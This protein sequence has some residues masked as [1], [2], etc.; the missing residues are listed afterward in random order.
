MSI[1]NTSESGNYE[2]SEKAQELFKID[3]IPKY[4]EKG[5]LGT[6]DFHTY[7]PK[8][9]NYPTIP[10]HYRV[11][12][13]NQVTGSSSFG[14]T[15]DYNLTAHINELIVGILHSFEVTA[16][17][18]KGNG[19]TITATDLK[20]MVKK[21]LKNQLTKSV[22]NLRINKGLTDAQA[23][24]VAAAVINDADANITYTIDG[25]TYS[26]TEVLTAWKDGKCRNKFAYCK[27]AGQKL[28][29]Q[30]T[31]SID[32]VSG[33]PLSGQSLSIL[34]ENLMTEDMNN[35]LD[36]LNTG[37]KPV[38]ISDLNRKGVGLTETVL[39]NSNILKD[40][41]A[42]VFAYKQ[43]KQRFSVVLPEMT[44]Y[45]EHAIFKRGGPTS[46]TLSVSIKR[47]EF[48]SM[49]KSVGTLMVHVNE[50]SNAKKFIEHG[51]PKAFS[52]AVPDNDTVYTG[53]N[54][55]SSSIYLVTQTFPMT[56]NA[57]ARE[58]SS[59]N[60]TRF[61]EISYPAA[62]AVS[63]QLSGLRGMIKNIYVYVKDTSVDKI[64]NPMRGEDWALGEPVIRHVTFG[65][66]E[67]EIALGNTLHSP[68]GTISVGRVVEIK[69]KFSLS[70]GSKLPINTDS[71]LESRII[72]IFNE[73]PNTTKRGWV[74]PLG[75]SNGGDPSL[76]GSGII[77]KAKSIATLRINSEEMGRYCDK[78]KASGT[79]DTVSYIVVCEMVNKCKTDAAGRISEEL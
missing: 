58:Y 35:F 13:L 71:E 3:K 61:V 6:L 41:S 30:M 78:V 49:I 67:P 64:E 63:V 66:A 19:R 8:S 54:L 11:Y 46:S 17:A 23:E 4:E 32:S 5:F 52:F 27:N 24:S 10:R 77:P 65:G 29:N 16:T 60:C 31:F 14:S 42:S 79:G 40:D 69:P 70:M 33:R 18:S 76:P 48:T 47:E 44:G 74:L 75:H 22:G 36:T 39:Q 28:I 38:L 7:T 73:G 72:S 2:T 50:K 56:P 34:Q 62:A 53:A 21:E 20:A 45:K 43:D 25:I 12:D 26:P 9:G 37:G 68:T 55:S 51:L 57:L 15:S 59:A 1:F